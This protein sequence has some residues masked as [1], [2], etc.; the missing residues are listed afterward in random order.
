MRRQYVV[1]RIADSMRQ[2]VPEATVIL[3]GSE[4]RGEARPD[5]DIDLL[6]LLRDGDKCTIGR[7]LEITREISEIEVD[8]GIII[9]PLIMSES[10]WLSM[11]TPFTVNVAKDGIR[12]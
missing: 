6:V 10:Q 3:Y 2:A 12:L 1:K 9:N 11:K 4:A 5:S 8:T 7:Q